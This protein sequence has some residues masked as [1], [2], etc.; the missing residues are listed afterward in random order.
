MAPYDK[1]IILARHGQTVFNRDGFIQ[2]RADSLLTYFG[3]PE[4]KRLP[5]LAEPEKPTVIYA[6]ALGRAA[7]TGSIYSQQL[8]APIHF[9][10]SI[11]ELSCGKWEGMRRSDVKGWSSTI[12]ESWDDRPPDG[13][14]YMDA[15]NRVKSF[16]DEITLLKAHQ[17]ILVVAH[18]GLNRV[19]LKLWLEMEPDAAR[20]IRCPHDTLYVIEPGNQVRRIHPDRGHEEGFLPETD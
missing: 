2:G 7:F 3:V 10:D 20:M 16:I 8:G 4:I 19:F 11:V 17:T 14:S 18:A 12:R 13:E 5:S 1:K 9:R 6:S 15:E